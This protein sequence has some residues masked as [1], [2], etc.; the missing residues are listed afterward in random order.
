MS[1]T[2]DH[3]N[4]DETITWLLRNA[5]HVLDIAPGSLQQGKRA[6]HAWMAAT[7]DDDRSEGD[8][9]TAAQ[10]HQG[11]RPR[12][13]A[14]NPDLSLK[15]PA[16]ARQGSD[17]KKPSRLQRPTGD[18]AHAAA[19]AGSR[20]M[21]VHRGEDA[22]AALCAVSELHTR[23][24]REQAAP[25][26]HPLHQAVADAEEQLTR[27]G[28]LTPHLLHQLH[29]ALTHTPLHPALRASAQAL[30]QLLDEQ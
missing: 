23:L 13:I 7:E 6:L 22:T 11:V 28:R 4:D 26:T 29:T 14:W 15:G 8:E 19:P 12:F 20:G 21:G 17:N 25:H 27:T 9:S 24:M 2:D 16:P 3:R 18:H 5:E 1:N 10:P 30:T